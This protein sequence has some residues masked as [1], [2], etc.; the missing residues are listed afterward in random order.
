LGG[1][2]QPW[3]EKSLKNRPIFMKIEEIDG[4]VSSVFEKPTGQ[5]GNF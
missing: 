4:P 1:N 2:R 5:I 3:I